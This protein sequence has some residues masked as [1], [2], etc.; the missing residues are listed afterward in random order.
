[1]K[2]R[3]ILFVFLAFSWFLTDPEVFSQTRTAVAKSELK[4]YV[5]EEESGYIIPLAS[6]AL[7]GTDLGSVTNEYGFFLIR[8][9]P[10]GTYTLVVS[11]IG[12]EEQRIQITIATDKLESTV[13][14]MAKKNY[15]LGE[16]TI[17]AS[18]RRWERMTP[19]GT[20]RMTVESMEKTPTL[21]VQSDMAQVLQTLPG[22]IFT[23]DRGGQIYVRGGA[24]IHN[25]VL[26]D[27]M[28]VINPFHSV[29]FMSVFDTEI[30]QSVDVYSAA[31]DARFGGRVSSI[32]DIRTRAG[33]R[34]EF[35]GT[36]SQSNIGYGLMLEG[37]LKPM[38]DSTIGSISYILSTK[39]SY[40][41][42]TAPVL[43]PWLDSLGLPYRY[44]DYYGKVSFME[45]NGNLFDIFGLH[46]SDA[47]N[48]KNSVSS[49]WTTTGGGFGFIVSPPQSN[50]LFVNRMAMSRYSA[51]FV[52]P[53]TT[54]KGTLYD[55]LDLSLK[56]VHVLEHFELTWAAEFSA[57]HTQ[58]QYTRWDDMH[59]TDD[60][61]TSD[62]II[63][64]QTKILLS[65]WIIE[66]G[67]HLR[68]YSAIFNLAPEPRL[69][70]RYNLTDN[71]S[72]NLA[73]GLY[74]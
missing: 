19:L 71:L 5:Y 70:V 59:M 51:D 21:G 45:K 62:A 64:F 48:Y 67:L 3:R 50:F 18:R 56:G 24:P 6:A 15:Q 34:S 29:G 52:D 57:I 1:M 27:G 44:N 69:K 63:L 22:V 25:K 16:A 55:N 60:L 40:L 2:T 13:I 49:S 73:G 17:T 35:H 12:F 72:L 33:N 4:G 68:V 20:Q 30:L 74:S 26:L 65:R 38:T 23:G 36:V 39:G 43:Y 46:Y 58:Y 42:M 41:R 10:L 32:M 28:T 8:K 61:Y 66:P 37:P 14:K 9:I 7:L 53:T 31:Y 47:V 54:P 11:C